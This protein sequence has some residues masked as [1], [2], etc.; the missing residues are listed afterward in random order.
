MGIIESTVPGVTGYRLVDPCARCHREE[1]V[2]SVDWPDIPKD[3]L[4]LVCG[5]CLWRKFNEM[6]RGPLRRS[7]IRAVFS[8]RLYGRDIRPRYS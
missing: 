1:G 3:E 2:F 6:P 8:R 5:R 7:L 4:F